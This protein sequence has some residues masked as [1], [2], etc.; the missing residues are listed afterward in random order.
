MRSA[1][2]GAVSDISILPWMEEL[3]PGAAQA[4]RNI[5]SGT[6]ARDPLGARGATLTAKERERLR[7]LV[8]HPKYNGSNEAAWRELNAWRGKERP[9]DI[10]VWIAQY[11]LFR[12]VF[13]AP[14]L[15]PITKTEIRERKAA[16]ASV[17]NRIVKAARELD[18]IVASDEI[19]ATQLADLWQMFR[20]KYGFP[21][22]F[23]AVFDLLGTLGYFIDIAA[24]HIKPAGPAPH[25]GKMRGKDAQTRAAVR[26]IVETCEQGFGSPMYETVRKLASASLGRIISIEKVRNSRRSDPGRK[27]AS[28]RRLRHGARR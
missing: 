22:N 23:C 9:S 24:K 21:E 16:L 20:T 8:N 17:A 18:G 15:P 1:C 6:L 25:L 4:A 26:H 3:A 5:S 11:E 12:A 14:D 27:S 7:R 19:I 10:E 13:R 2:G 28:R